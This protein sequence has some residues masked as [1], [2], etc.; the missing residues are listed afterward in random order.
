MFRVLNCVATE[1]DWRLVALAALVCFL[2]SLVAISLFHRAYATRGK[3]R[4]AWLGLAGAAP[5]CG[6]WSTHFIAMLA[7]DPGVGIAY[8]IPLLALSLIA[9]AVVTC[10]GLSFAVFS[11][12]RWGAAIGGGVVGAGVACMHYSGMWAIQLPDISPGFR[13]WSW[14][15]SFSACCSAWWRWRSRC[16]AM[17]CAQP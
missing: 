3:A 8:D 7:Y 10:A 13:L 9:A 17:T 11:S 16:V 14:P 5:G 4:A 1:H 15:R 12:N 2:A 6:I